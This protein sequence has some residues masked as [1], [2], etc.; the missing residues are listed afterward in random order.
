MPYE[1][2]MH[3]PGSAAVQDAKV[4]QRFQPPSPAEPNRTG[5][6]QAEV[7]EVSV[8]LSPLRWTVDARSESFRF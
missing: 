4:S 1:Y 8:I 3:L 2:T 6:E 5:D 7:S